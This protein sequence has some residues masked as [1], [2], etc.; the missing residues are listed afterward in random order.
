MKAW[1]VMITMRCEFTTVIRYSLRSKHE[2]WFRLTYE[3]HDGPRPGIE[4]W[5]LV[6]MEELQEFT[7]VA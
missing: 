2:A 7:K 6:A 4:K 1:V 3:V 5:F